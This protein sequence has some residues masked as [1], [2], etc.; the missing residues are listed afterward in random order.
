MKN[1][2][3]ELFIPSMVYDSII[4][5]S[6]TRLKELGIGGLILDLDNTIVAWDKEDM[7]PE[8][9]KWLCDI[10][11][12]DLKICILSNNRTLWRVRGIAGTLDVP[13]IARAGKPARK[14]FKQALRI[15]DLSADKVA[16]VGD[17]LFTDVL[18]GNRL[19]MLTI[20][21]PPLSTKEFFT[22]KMMRILEKAVVYYLKHRGFWNV[23]KIGEQS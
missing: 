13:F 20:W 23:K 11:T 10:K 3:I 18:G 2:L 14:G 5:I 16:V 15:L 4:D 8:V 17:Q 21:V 6:F 12:T 7:S 22:T 9:A 19:S 1:R